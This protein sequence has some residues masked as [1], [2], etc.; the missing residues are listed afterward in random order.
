MAIRF[1][2]LHLYTRC[3]YI[4]NY[5]QAEKT[6]QQ[7]PDQARKPFSS[8][9]LLEN[10]K[11]ACQ[12]AFAITAINLAALFCS[13]VY[14]QAPKVKFTVEGWTAHIQIPDGLSGKDEFNFI[15]L[16]EIGKK[17]TDSASMAII[18][19]VALRQSFENFLYGVRGQCKDAFS[20]A[21]DM[22][23][24]W[25]DGNAEITVRLYP[26]KENY[27]RLKAGTTRF[28]QESIGD[29][30][31]DEG[32]V[33]TYRV[34]EKYMASLDTMAIPKGYV[35]SYGNVDVISED[36]ALGNRAM[37]IAKSASRI[38]SLIAS[39]RNRQVLFESKAGEAGYE[40]RDSTIRM[41]IAD[42]V[43]Y[44]ATISHEEAHA[45]FNEQISDS[46]AARMADVYYSMMGKFSQFRIGSLKRQPLIMLFKEST[47]MGEKNANRGH[48]WSNE[49]E[50]FA[51]G[52]AVLLNFTDRFFEKLAE[53]E[54][55]DPESGKLARE[56][57]RTIFTCYGKRIFPDAAY[58][59]LC[60][61]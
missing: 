15:L 33:S 61:E 5:V 58:S 26:N 2:Q 45:F 1:F 28:R 21:Y 17:T 51:S 31:M 13:P 60:L 7:A 32:H 20:N 39:K 42:S 25:K 59:G 49:D 53:L 50:L 40:P 9:R 30:L 10:A 23:A 18:E 29:T 52:T 3:F 55:A 47:Y 48:P 35:L 34:P 56:I 43:D 57:A 14:S 24:M 6:L 16:K 54:N 36:S 44:P 22:G 41:S 46:N 12:Y 4:Y 37:L 8:M 38:N 27:V 19:N 11:R